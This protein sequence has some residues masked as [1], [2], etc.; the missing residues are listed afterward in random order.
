M[1]AKVTFENVVKKYGNVLAVDDLSLELEDGKFTVLVGPSGC[2]KTTTLRMIAGLENVTSGTISIDKTDVTSL[3]PKD[4]DISMVFQNYALYAHLTIAENIV[5]PLLARGGKRVEV[6]GRLQEVA[7]M[8]NISHL[9]ERKPKELSGGQQQRVAIGRAIV[10]APKVFLFDEPLS[11]LD[12]KLRVEMRTELLRLQRQLKTTTVYVT[13]DQEEAM[14]LSDVMIVMKDGKIL[15]KGSPIDIYENPNDTFVASFVGSPRMNLISGLCDEGLFTSESGIK[16]NVK[17]I[18][19]RKTVLGIRPEE[20]LLVPASEAD[21]W[22]TIEIVELLGPRAIVT[23]QVAS[24]HLTAI[25]NSSDM[26]SIQEGSRVGVK[27]R[28]D[29]AHLFDE[30]TQVRL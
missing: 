19:Q 23:L 8:L 4:R 17:N 14:T 28:K 29:R 22:A 10:R 15:Q 2:G 25:V 12:A 18:G 6:Q 20:I 30:K 9:L 7:K 16:C 13:H 27:F 1:M 5:F 26:G 11:N 21:F 3:E 24:E